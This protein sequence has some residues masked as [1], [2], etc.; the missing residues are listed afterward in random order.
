[1]LSEVSE[2]FTAELQKSINKN[3]LNN[4]KSG[5]EVL[6]DAITKITVVMFVKSMVDL[7]LVKF[8]N[9][10][11]KSLVRNGEGFLDLIALRSLLGPR[12]KSE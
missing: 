9:E 12:N 5:A 11:E 2:A 3:Y 1:M 10:D 6:G 4:A 7:G 8:S